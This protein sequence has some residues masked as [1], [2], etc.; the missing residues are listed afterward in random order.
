MPLSTDRKKERNHCIF[1]VY[2]TFYN[3]RFSNP[4]FEKNSGSAPVIEIATL[5]YIRVL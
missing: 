4:S 3:E 2:A 1:L 5:S